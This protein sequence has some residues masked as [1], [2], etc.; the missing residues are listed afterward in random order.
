MIR[1]SRPATSC[2]GPHAYSAVKVEGRRAYDLAREG[3][4]ARARRAARSPSTAPSGSR[5]TAS[6]PSSRSSARPGTYVRQLVAALGDAYCEQL[7]RTAI[8]PFELADADPERVVPLAEALAFLPE[9]PLDDDRGRR[10]R[11]RPPRSRADRRPDAADCRRRADRDRPPARRRDPARRGVRA[12]KVTSLPDA[13]PRPRKVAVG[14]FD[15][16]HLGHREVIRG[17]DTVLTFD[18]HPLSVVAPQARAEAARLAGDQARPDRRA[19]RGRA[20]D[21]PVR[22]RLRVEVGRAVHRG[23]PG[24]EARRDRTSRWARTSASAR[25]RRATR[26]CC[27]S[28]SEFETRVVPLVEVEDETVSSTHIRGLVA[29]GDVERAAALPGRAVHARGRGGERRPPRARARLPDREHRAG[30]PPRAP[31]AT[32]S[33]PRGRTG[34]WRR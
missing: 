8:G 34:T 19:R 9:R 15:G 12:V 31:R 27:R 22:P 1:R 30:R 5:S 11:P 16:V 26:S 10:R 29:A 7:E 23:G 25:G 17:N 32:A 18:P 33:T 13:E 3:E 21:D 4:D 14:T 20:R 2:S 24:R 6:A 28:R